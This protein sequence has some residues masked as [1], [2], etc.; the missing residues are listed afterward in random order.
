MTTDRNNRNG[1]QGP[2]RL[3]GPVRVATIC[4]DEESAQRLA[5]FAVST[6]LV[7]V[8][9]ELDDYLA[10]ERD[11]P[12]QW[13]RSPIDACLID[14]DRD[15]SRARAMAERIH[16]G[17]PDVA[18][19]AVSEDSQPD[20]IIQAMRAGCSE[21]LL[22]PLTDDQLLQSI[23]RVAAR[24][25]EIQTTGRVVIL[26]G[27]KGGAGVTTIA[28]H[29][30]A[31]LAKEHSRRTLLADLHPAMGDAEL[32]L[33]LLK[34]QYSFR[35]LAS[36]AERLDGE[37]LQSFVLHHRSGL[38]LLPAPVSPQARRE[39]ALEAICATIDFLRCCYDFL[40]IDCPPGLGE[41]TL[42]VVQYADQVCVIAVP[43]VAALRN[44]ARCL[45]GL[46]RANYPRDRIGVVINRWTKKNTIT[47]EQIEDAI[48]APIFWKLPNQYHEVIRIINDGDP[49]ARASGSDLARS[50][51]GL[52]SQLVSKAGAVPHA[53]KAGKG[54]LAMLGG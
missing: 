47:D 6:P 53:A 26:L 35:D 19:F 38:D 18:L 15:R 28:T 48:H 27:A 12:P 39:V 33:G 8:Q 30:G 3:G 40:L 36:N 13:T 11:V 17:L 5:G 37:L 16:A 24:K 21:Y 7:R 31:I 41:E 1:T 46:A 2:S 44:I 42:G 49:S 52:A 54:L 23:A 29:L 9:V 25:K 10:E 4:L 43:E 32:Y 45:D 22:K 34:Y 51:S 14:F 20:M 50:V